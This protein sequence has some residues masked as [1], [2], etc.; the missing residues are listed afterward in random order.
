MCSLSIAERLLRRFEEGIQHAK[1]ALDAYQRLDDTV[2]QAD[3][4]GTLA[5]LL[6]DDEQYNAAEEAASHAIELLPEKGEEFLACQSHR[7]LGD[8]HHSKG[9]GEKAAH[10]FGEAL[11]IASSF[12]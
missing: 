7:I 11:R 6:Y 8:I 1:E 5:R 10:H 12:K 4:L 2:G 3:C 9:E